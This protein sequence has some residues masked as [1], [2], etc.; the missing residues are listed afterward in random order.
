MFSRKHALVACGIIA[1]TCLLFARPISAFYARVDFDQRE[2][3]REEQNLAAQWGIQTANEAMVRLTGI[4]IG[5]SILTLLGLAAT[6][7]MNARALKQAQ[8]SLQHA[9]GEGLKRQENAQKELRAY[10]KVQIDTIDYG[11]DRNSFKVVL[12]TTNYGKTPAEEVCFSVNT[13]FGD[14]K[15]SPLPALAPFLPP[16]RIGSGQT[17]DTPHT[18]SGI[19]EDQDK[20]FSDPAAAEKA[21]VF[22]KI[23]YRD[24]FGEEFYTDFA[25]SF[26]R[27]GNTATNVPHGNA[28]T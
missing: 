21:I 13:C 20:L 22:G 2:F 28:S 16:I 11:T 10:L 5:L 25:Y 12:K 18:I 23:K 19:T 6:L 7:A 9:Q 27:G 15:C 4:Q 17:Q 14:P 3:A 26:W 1:F 8:E 24:V